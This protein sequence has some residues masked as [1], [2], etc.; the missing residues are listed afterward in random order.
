MIC[1]LKIC[2]LFGKK[3]SRDKSPLRD[4]SVPRDRCPLQA[5]QPCQVGVPSSCFVCGTLLNKDYLLYTE[6]QNKKVISEVA[7]KI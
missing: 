4:S 7:S 1:H 6:E 3:L 5:L 2:I